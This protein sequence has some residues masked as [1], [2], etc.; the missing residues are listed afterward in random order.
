MTCTQITLHALEAGGAI[1][2]VPEKE[3][4]RMMPAD[5]ESFIEPSCP[6]LQ[7][8]VRFAPLAQ[9]LYTSPIEIS[10]R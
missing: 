8:G 9:I 2:R 10:G 1:T 7:P 4:W 3:L 5:L 6:L